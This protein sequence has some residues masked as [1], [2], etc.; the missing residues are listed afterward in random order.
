MR[1]NVTRRQKQFVTSTKSGRSII[2]K[3]PRYLLKITRSIRRVGIKR[4]PRGTNSARAI[5]HACIIDAH[6]SKAVQKETRHACAKIFQITWATLARSNVA[7]RRT[8]RICFAFTGCPTSRQ[9]RNRGWIMI[10]ILSS[11]HVSFDH[12]HVII[13]KLWGICRC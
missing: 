2:I 1:I 11:L 10:G 4:R 5:F 12:V 7:R 13:N 3:L 9:A 8:C 6:A